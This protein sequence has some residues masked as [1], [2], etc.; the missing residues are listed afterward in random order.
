VEEVLDDNTEYFYVSIPRLPLIQRRSFTSLIIFSE[1]FVGMVIRESV[2]KT[3]DRNM[4][5]DGDLAMLCKSMV[6][7]NSTTF[8]CL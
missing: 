1:L 6:P 5:I 8:C 4:R 7:G 3:A 2:I